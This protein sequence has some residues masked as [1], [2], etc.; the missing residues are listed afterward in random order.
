MTRI[1]V[2]NWNTEI[3]AGVFCFITF[4]SFDKNYFFARVVKGWDI[5]ESQYSLKAEPLEW[6]CRKIEYF[7]SLANWMYERGGANKQII[8]RY[9]EIINVIGRHKIH[10]FNNAFKLK[11]T[12]N[13]K[14]HRREIQSFFLHAT[15]IIIIVLLKTLRRLI[16][17]NITALIWIFH[18][19]AYK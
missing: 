7:S 1:F 2:R 18:T 15:V 5:L 3:L 8:N 11:Y 16:F 17:K 12:I 10:F 6:P 14:N 4:F 19:R 13:K 9:R